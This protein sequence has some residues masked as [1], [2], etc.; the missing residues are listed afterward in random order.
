MIIG[1]TFDADPDA[2]RLSAV[3]TRDEV[4]PGSR[5][6]S[7]DRTRSGRPG[8]MLREVN[9]VRLNVLDE[10]EGHP[11]VFLHGLGG[12]WRDWEP[13]LDSL[14]DRFRCIV[15]EH[16]GHGRSELTRGDYSH[17]AVRR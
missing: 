7:A 2:A 6:G 17:P 10:G 3:L 5:V 14:S 11:V 9:G 1:A 4:L 12:C 8:D 15:I 13:Q 16:R